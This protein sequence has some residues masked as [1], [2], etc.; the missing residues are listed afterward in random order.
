MD[1]QQVDSGCLGEPLGLNA[2]CM[3]DPSKPTVTNDSHR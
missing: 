2:Q 3:V 1:S